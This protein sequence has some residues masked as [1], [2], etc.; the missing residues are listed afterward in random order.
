M[1]PNKARLCWAAAV[2]MVLAAF[3]SAIYFHAGLPE[4]I[5][6]HWNIQG[7]VDG[8]GSRDTVYLMPGIMAFMIVMF[9]GLPALSP[10]PFAVDEFRS[11]YLVMMTLTVALMGYLHGVI[12]YATLHPAAPIGKCLIS[13][14]MLFLAA[15]GNFMGK[16]RRNL[17][18]GIRT[19]WTL[20]SER[21]WTDT[22]R[23]GAWFFTGGGLLGAILCLV[24]LPVWTAFVPLAVVVVVP[25]AYSYIRYKE[26]E[27]QGALGEGLDAA[28]PSEP[29]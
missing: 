4:R 27:K 15:M 1:I 20:A 24:G 19:P 21:V 5:P 22:H 3:G 18:M 26:L 12:L 23:L 6:T 29:A 28:R 8:Y 10:K 2:V 17:Y 11:T 7:Q 13:G 9:A 14:I 16:I 25:I